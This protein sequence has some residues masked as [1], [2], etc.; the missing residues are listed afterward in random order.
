MTSTTTTDA[1]RHPG[2]AAVLSLFIPGVGQIYNGDFV[3]G[4]ILLIVTPGLWIGSGGLFG[5][6]CHVISAYTA[7]QRAKDKSAGLA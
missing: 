2:V 3:R 7:H 6:V 5:W 4:I 1:P